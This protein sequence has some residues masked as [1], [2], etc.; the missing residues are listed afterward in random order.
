MRDEHE[1]ESAGAERHGAVAT[2]ESV[3]RAANA[4]RVQAVLHGAG[5]ALHALPDREESS[6][7]GG[8]PGAESAGT[9]VDPE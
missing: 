3:V 6:D 9:A 5:V 2:D 1:S 4:D 7:G 8:S